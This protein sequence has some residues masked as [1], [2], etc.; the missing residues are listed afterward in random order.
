[1]TPAI[2][3]P[4][5]LLL[6][7]F[8]SL[9]DPL[10]P[11][12]T[13]NAPKKLLDMEQTEVQTLYNKVEMMIPM[14]DGVKLCCEAYVPKNADGH[15]PI[16]LER[17]PY[18]SGPYGP[19]KYR[20][21]RGSHKFIENGYIFAFED[22]RGKNQSEGEF[23][24]VRPEDGGKYHPNDIDESTD[25]YDTI[26]Y[27][28]KNLKGNN[29]NVGMYG[30][31]YPGFYTACGGIDSHPAL[32][33][34]SPQAPVSEWFKGDDFHHNGA[35]FVEDAFNFYSWFGQPTKGPRTPLPSRSPNEYDWFLGEM[36]LPNLTAKYIPNQ[37]F[38][39]QLMDNGTYDDFWQRRTLETH[40]KNIHCAVLTV[41]GMFDAE[42]MYGALNVFQAIGK[43]NPRIDN[44][45]VM[46]PWFH[47]GWSFRPGRTFGDIDFGSDTS[48]YFQ[49]KV[50]FPFFDHYLRGGPDPNL[51]KA[52]IF[53]T[54][55]N[56]WDEF[57]SWPPKVKQEK[58]YFEPSK[59]LAWR[60]PTV[61]DATDGDSYVN[62]PAHPTD[63]SAKP[64]R[65]RPREYMIADQRFNEAKPD[66]LTY[67][68][69]A[70][71]NDVT[72]YGPLKVDLFA[73]TTGTDADFVVKVIDVLPPDAPENTI[74]GAQVSMANY[75]M[76]V[77]GDVF[78]GK[79]R[80]SFSDPI[81]FTPNEPTEVAFGMND[82][83]HTFLKGH[84]IMVQLQSSWFPLVDINPN[85]F[86]DIYHAKPEDFQSAKITLLHS[87]KYPSHLEFGIA[88]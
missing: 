15:S 27:L 33:A 83:C 65:S 73:T 87:A 36:P 72:T 40:L 24:D 7:G 77:R 34:I 75:E 62:D 41:G 70:L 1:M 17:S 39:Q 11:E 19:N 71:S 68:T 30:I 66:V 42:D 76:L 55:A 10:K 25:T 74:H 5:A 21:F 82:M 29:G 84:R 88:Q 44:R 23:V 13:I 81:P 35:F 64:L 51:P 60:K 20:G 80:K 8:G 56:K 69:D 9:I 54:G 31:S 37:L 22:V 4:L 85:R 26:D 3:K 78:R 6:L 32:K 18:G 48:S 52:L 58:L 16:L 47:G 79:F 67:E 12:L 50:E 43:L 38:W 53:E 14:R 63:Y 2:Y 57:A 61:S 28:V 86:E 46:G 45:L 49:D 59:A